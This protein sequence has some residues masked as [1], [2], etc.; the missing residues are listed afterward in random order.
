MADMV[1]INYFKYC[2]NYI[3]IVTGDFMFTKV[4]S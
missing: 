2:K 3:K 1:H 4:C